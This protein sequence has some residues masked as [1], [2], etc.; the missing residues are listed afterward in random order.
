VSESQV[1]LLLD[2]IEAARDYLAQASHSDR[3]LRR[4]ELEKRADYHLAE[5]VKLLRE[6]PVPSI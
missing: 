5:A 3:F 4:A 6:Q 1:T 2:R